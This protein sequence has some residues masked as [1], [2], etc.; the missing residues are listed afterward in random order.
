M[1]RSV[2]AAA[3]LAIAGLLALP[4]AAYAAAITLGPAIPLIGN[5]YAAAVDPTSTTA[6]VVI[7]DF[8][9]L[10]SLDLA[11]GTTTSVPVGSVPVDLAISP[12]GT[13]AYISNGASNTITRLSLPSMMPLPDVAVVSPDGIAFTPDG[14][15]AYV[16]SVTTNTVAVIDV[17]TG[18]LGTPIPVGDQP[19]NVAITP[20]GAL[21]YVTDSASDS[22]TVFRVATGLVIATIPVARRRGASKF[23]PDGREVWVASVPRR[24]GLDHRRRLELGRSRSC[25]SATT[26]TRSPSART[27]RSCS[28]PPTPATPCGPSMSRLAPRA[29]RSASGP[30]RCSS[31]SPRMARRPTPQTT[32]TR[33]C[34]CSHSIP[35]LARSCPH[36]RPSRRP[37]LELGLAPALGALS[38]VAGVALVVA[39]RRRRI[40]HR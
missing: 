12:D 16:V 34:R 38:L 15:T 13:L 21:G 17:A 40:P 23:S 32:M 26:R 1:F 8:D 27:G 18:A 24:L 10:V 14:T 5:P 37:G 30:D 29:P 7:P 20:D 9:I 11:T 3:V 39:S 25:P 22:V 19:V 6:L 31:P 2:S 36:R 33:S 28:S 4:A 35:P